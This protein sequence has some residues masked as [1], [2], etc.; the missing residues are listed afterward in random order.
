MLIGVPAETPSDES[1]ATR[2]GGIRGGDTVS[3][4]GRGKTAL[5]LGIPLSRSAAP[6][7][8]VALGTVRTNNNWFQSYDR[9]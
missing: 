7:H 6:E 2:G 5:Y 1:Y 9:L 8:T 4:V 3:R